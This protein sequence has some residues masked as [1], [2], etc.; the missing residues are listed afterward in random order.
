M[1]I[2]YNRRKLKQQQLKRKFK[3]RRLY[4]LAISISIIIAISFG[5][6]KLFLTTQ[7]K[8]LTY[9]VEHYMTKGGD[10]SLK[11]L[12]VKNMT[13]IF[14]D[15]NSAVVEVSGLGKNDPHATTLIKGHYKKNSFDSWV[16][17][18]SYL[19]ENDN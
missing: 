1:G 11:L 8:D 12:R 19:V 16:L 6:F 4:T 2:K 15:G 9:A 14:S 17:E 7:C 5:C 13:L 18:D 3:I 10:K